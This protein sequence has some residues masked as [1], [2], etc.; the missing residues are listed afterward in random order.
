MYSKAES[1]SERTPQR[2]NNA[3]NRLCSPLQR[4]SHTRMGPVS[5]AHP[6]KYSCYPAQKQGS[7]KMR[8]EDTTHNKTNICTAHRTSSKE[9]VLLTLVP[10]SF[11]SLL[12]QQTVLYFMF[13]RWW[14]REG[15]AFFYLLSVQENRLSQKLQQYWERQCMKLIGN[16]S[17]REISSSPSCGHQY[18]LE[19]G[20]VAGGC[21]SHTVSAFPYH[22][23]EKANTEGCLHST[24]KVMERAFLCLGSEYSNANMRLH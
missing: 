12:H 2:C 10:V 7:Q 11:S 24:T 6:E 3:H 13:P 21:S 9:N 18:C 16:I 15:I 22:P 1:S 4:V 8:W 23:K 19:E 14:K 20:S 17:T 5:G